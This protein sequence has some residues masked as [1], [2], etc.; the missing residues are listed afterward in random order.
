MVAVQSRQCAPVVRSFEKGH[1]V[2]TP[3]T[4]NGT[5]ADGLDVPGAIMG[6]AILQVLRDSEG[7]AVAVADKAI[8]RSFKEFAL[9]GVPA[10]Y[11]GAA[12]LAALNQLKEAGTIS[13]GQRVLLLNTG[14]PAVALSKEVT[15]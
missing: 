11:E 13:K 15:P 1:D 3:V 5:I 8:K 14:G 10:G 9:A 6:H 2:V 4:S 12:T 7:T